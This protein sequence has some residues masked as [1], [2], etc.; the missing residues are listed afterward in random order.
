MPYLIDGNNLIGYL[1]HLDIRSPA[2]RRELISE[3]FIFHKVKKT[4]V[5][6]V[7]DGPPDSAISQQDFNGTA[8]YLHYPDIGQDAD[9]IAKKIISKETDL[10]QFFVVSSDREIIEYAKSKKAKSLKCD[11]FHKQ[12]KRA[13]KQYRKIR[14]LEKNVEPPSP[15]EVQFWSKIFEKK[16]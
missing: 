8:F 2:S 3:L 7:F 4:R 16:K 10:R 11:E 13:L 12:L 5:E 1:P 9:L 15:L 14:E 6:V